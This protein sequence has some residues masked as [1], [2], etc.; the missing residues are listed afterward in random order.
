MVNVSVSTWQSIDLPKSMC[1][2]CKVNT[3]SL[4]RLHNCLLC[5]FWWKRHEIVPVLVHLSLKSELKKHYFLPEL[6][7]RRCLISLL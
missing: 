1:L 6:R 5:V 2:F 3:T 4:S 7:Y